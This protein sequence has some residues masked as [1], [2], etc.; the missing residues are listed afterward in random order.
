ML[1]NEGTLV[2]EVVGICDQGLI[3][4]YNEDWPYSALEL[5]L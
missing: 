3:H 4:G 2:V 5:W 1:V